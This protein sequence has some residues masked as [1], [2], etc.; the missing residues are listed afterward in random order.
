[1]ANNL[2]TTPIGLDAVIHKAQNILYNDLNALWGIELEGYPRC[3]VINR[4]NNITIE[5]Y[6]SD[7]EYLSLISAE[8][9]KFFFTAESDIERKRETNTIQFETT[10]E[11]YFIV[12][13]SVIKPSILHRGDEE[14]RNDVMNVLRRIPDVYIDSI[15][16][17][18]ERVFQGFNF[19]EMQDMHPYHAFK[20]VLNVPSFLIN[21][22]VCE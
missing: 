4:D 14:I 18:I 12:D 8:Y 13:V 3:Y 10:I 17:N 21:Q 2:K 19:R 16:T 9:N 20:I 1:M 5:H 7:F 11:L 15:V 22:K 6:V